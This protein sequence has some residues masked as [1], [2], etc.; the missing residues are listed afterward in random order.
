MQGSSETAFSQIQKE[1]KETMDFVKIVLLM[2]GI[3]LLLVVLAGILVIV[4]PDVLTIPYILYMNLRTTTR[5]EVHR[6]EI[7]M[8]GYINSKTYD[9]FVNL[10]EENPQVTTLVEGI[11]HGSLDDDTMIKL[12]YYVR[13]QGLN[14]HLRST[15]QIDSGGVDLFLAGVDRT[16]ERGAH[17]GVHSWSDGSTQAKDVPVEDPQHRQNAQYIKDML[18]S[19]DFYWFTI[20]AAPADG[21][22]EMTEEEI[23]QYGLLTR[24]IMA[25]STDEMPGVLANKIE[26]DGNPDGEIVIVYAQ[27]GPMLDILGWRFGGYFPKVDRDK[28][29]L[30]SV[31]QA[32]TFAP[33]NFT[34]API[35]L[36]DAAAANGT[37]VQYLADM[38][39]YFV[40]Q[41]RKVYVVGKTFGAQLVQDLLASQG[42]IAEGYLIVSSR[43]DMQEEA[44]EMLLDGQGVQFE[45]GIKPVPNPEAFSGD[46][47]AGPYAAE[48]LAR[49]KGELASTR[50]TEILADV[51]MDNV[52][53]V[54]GEQDERMG[55]LSDEEIAFLESKGVTIIASDGD[56]KQL[57]KEGP[58][59]EGMT[60]LIGEEYMK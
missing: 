27:G 42:N 5:F 43:L 46:S 45:N 58:M 1:I 56:Y 23:I 60:L 52:I 26:V 36:E 48:N 39:Q 10:L 57:I 15:S 38:I 34:E 20:Y 41:D 35:T 54:Y 28:V 37:S 50:F 49:L 24:P 51:P 21:I 55:G 25:P 13:D 40:D 17:I 29:Y 11:V 7:W 30:V 31:H 22:H 4:F 8:D 59:D 18:G 44:W 2:M 19:E 12:A 9:Q 33:Y 47:D 6:N 32:Q 14:T 16:M 53:F 3:L